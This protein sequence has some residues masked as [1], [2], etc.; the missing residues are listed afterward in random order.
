MVERL[1]S[2]GLLTQLLA[3]HAKLGR[4]EPR[5]RLPQMRPIGR[6]SLSCVNRG[7]IPGAP[8]AR[9][10]TSSQSA[11]HSEAGASSQ[12]VR[13][14]TQGETAP[15]SRPSPSQETSSSVCEASAGET[16]PP[17]R[18]ASQG[19]KASNKRPH[20]RGI[21]APHARPRP[22]AAARVGAPAPA[23]GGVGGKRAGH[24]KWSPAPAGHRCAGALAPS[25]PPSAPRLSSPVSPRPVSL[26]LSTWRG[27]L[28]PE[29][30]LVTIWGSGGLRSGCARN[31]TPMLHRELTSTP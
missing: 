14:R 13:R 28:A 2:A 15:A 24:P 27:V 16:L 17:R 21:S 11:P 20:G 4:N 9:T 26:S 12:R 6:P 23:S 30:G 5:Y 3:Q 25:T 18:A 7:G 29:Q 19:H 1:C 22:R 31:A 10:D 8:R